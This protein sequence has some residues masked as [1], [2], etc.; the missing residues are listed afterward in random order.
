[1]QKKI[2][3]AVDGS[4]ATDHAVDYVGMMQGALIKELNVTLLFI[5]KPVPPFMRR[6]GQSDPAIYKQLK[7]LEKSNWDEAQKVLGMAKER[8]IKH[9]MAEEVIDTKPMPRAVG[10]AKD[11]LFEAEHGLY[12]AVVLGR[13]GL[14]KAQELFLG[15]VTNKVVQHASRLPIWVVG[16]RVTS[17]KVL[18][19]VDGSEGSLKA[20]DH[21]AF[22]LGGNPDCQVTLFH[23]G[24]TL[25]NYCT[26]DF[27]E[28]IKEKIEG[29]LMSSDAECMDDFFSR[30]VKVLTDAG[31]EMEQ[32]QTKSVRAK[33]GVASAIVSQ[34]KKNDYG[35]VVLGR[36]GENRSFFLGHVSD[37]VLTKS[38]DHAVWIVG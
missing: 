6:A 5:M 11:I 7:S 27:S 9:G 23:V 12:D 21:M 30:A 15:S 35:T 16:G 10:A 33:L 25:A 26:L 22:L 36:R 1:M 38:E 24:A 14:S 18:C 28:D 4:S 19:A 3:I 31:L 29:E 2:L 32:V 34:M 37:N 8:L 17:R 20:V 13:R